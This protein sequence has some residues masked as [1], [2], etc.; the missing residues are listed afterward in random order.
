MGRKIIIDSNVLVALYKADDST[1]DRAV[2]TARSLHDD[3]DIFIALNLVVQETAT[4]ISMKAGQKE[5][6]EFY[7][8]RLSVIDQEITLDDDLEKLSWNIFLRQNKK[9]TSFVDCANLALFEKYKLDGILSFDKF[10]PNSV[11]VK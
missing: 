2:E 8:K 4:V 11:L 6:R 7:Q 10:Y 3:G 1:H 5:A 9:G